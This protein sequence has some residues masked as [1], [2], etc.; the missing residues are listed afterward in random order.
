MYELVIPYNC[1]QTNPKIRISL[2]D[3]FEKIIK[4]ISGG[5]STNVAVFIST[6]SSIFVFNCHAFNVIIFGRISVMN[7]QLPW[8]FDVCKYLH[9]YKHNV[10]YPNVSLC[11]SNWLLR[12]FFSKTPN[13]AKEKFTMI[14]CTWWYSIYR[15]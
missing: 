5:I 3:I 10:C 4:R 15:V 8:T 7:F 9:G 1:R 13:L 6:L 11:G 2:S 14:K 12:K